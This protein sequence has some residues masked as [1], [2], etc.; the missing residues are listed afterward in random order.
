MCPTAWGD[1][2]AGESC[3]LVFPAEPRW[4]RTA[5]EAVRTLI[6]PAGAAVAET[7]ALL[8]SEVVTNAIRATVGASTPTCTVPVVLHA[9]RIG[10]GRLRVRV[11]DGA[12]GTPAVPIRDAAD[13]AGAEGGRGLMLLSACAT[14]WGVCRHRPGR[15]KSVWF[16]L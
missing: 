13:E 1:G 2:G 8:T 6:T 16:D 5:R 7:A 15:G 10:A 3:T 12:P 4:V 9:V 14:G 11:R